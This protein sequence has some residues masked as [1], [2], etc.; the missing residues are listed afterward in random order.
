MSRFDEFACIVVNGLCVLAFI[1]TSP[2][3]MP[4]WVLGKIA[5][6]A[7]LKFVD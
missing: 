1:I 2:I 5:E 6:K 7:G 4:I 3:I